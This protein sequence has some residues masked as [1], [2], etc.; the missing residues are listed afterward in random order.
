[1]GRV[2]PETY[3]RQAVAAFRNSGGEW[4]AEEAIAGELSAVKEIGDDFLDVDD[5]ASAAAVFLGVASAVLDKY[6]S[7]LDEDGEIGTVLSECADGLGTCLDGL[8][9]DP[10]NAE[11]RQTILR[12]LFDIYLFD[13]E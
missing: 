10:E 2:T 5:Y 1:K 12:S 7:Y 9:T 6:E 13:L 4:D 11:Q 8:P 3:R